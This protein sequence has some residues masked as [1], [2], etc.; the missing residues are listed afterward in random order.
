V[1]ATDFDIKVPRRTNLDINVFSA[2]VSVDGVEG[3]EKLNGFSSR[4]TLNDVVGSVRAHT[5]SGAIIVRTKN[6]EPNQSFD[7][8]TF[9]GNIELHV[10]ESAR[11]RVTFKSFSGR[12]N[13]EMPLTL[14][15]GSRRSLTADLGGGGDGTFRFS[16]FSGNVRIDR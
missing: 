5:F 14:H 11:G 10:P 6:W 1:V 7:F 3:S 15:S 16:T 4:V 9:S 2:S 8:D 13:S 12:L